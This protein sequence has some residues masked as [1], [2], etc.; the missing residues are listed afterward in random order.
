MSDFPSSVEQ[1][2]DARGNG[3]Q[4]PAQILR[5]IYGHEFLS[6]VEGAGFSVDGL[7]RIGCILPYV[8][9]RH[10]HSIGPKRKCRSQIGLQMTSTA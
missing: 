7:M 8:S 2:Q 1:D 10:S 4:Q 3:E 6:Y 5:Q 9:D